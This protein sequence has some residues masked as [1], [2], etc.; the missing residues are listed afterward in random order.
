M[1]EIIREKI[2]EQYR[3]EVPYSCQVDVVEFKERKGAKDYIK[4]DI[5]V[6]KDSQKGII[7][8]TQ[9]SAIKRLST[10]SRVDIEGFLGR[11]V[12]LEVS[13]KAVKG[14]RDD[15]NLLDKFGY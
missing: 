12:F 5:V 13:V 4:V 6:E 2:F 10:A 9:G 3:Q 15:N 7:M 8:G 11:P 14:W 1:S